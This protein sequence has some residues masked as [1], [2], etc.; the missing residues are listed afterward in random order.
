[1]P[2]V[3]DLSRAQSD[4][5]RALGR[6][7]AGEDRD[8]GQRV[9]EAGE[10]ISHLLAG[11]LKLTRVHSPD[12]HAFDQPV[13]ELGKALA[14]LVGQL[15]TVHLAAVED[16]VYVNDIRIRSDARSGMRDLG[17]DLRRHGMGGLSFHAPLDDRA[18][19]DLV[20]VLSAEPAP[21]HPRAALAER[22]RERGITS[23]ETAGIFRFRT[24]GERDRRRVPEEVVQRMYAVAAETLD[25]L[26]AGRALNPLPLRRAV[27]E[28]LDTDVA[29]PAFWAAPPATAPLHAAHAVE[30]TVL[31]LLLARAARF[32]AAFLQ[33]VGI[34]AMVHDV[35]YF[36]PGLDG[37]PDAL[38]RHPL[39]GARVLL[40]QRGFQEGKL[41]RL[42]AV[43]EHHRD[44]GAAASPASAAGLVLRIAEDYANGV[45]LYAARALRADLLGA[46]LRAGTRYSAPLVQVLVNALGRF[47]PGT[48]VELA[49]GRRA[50]VA[51]PARGPDLWAAPLLRILDAGGTP[52]AELVDAARGVEIRR[53]VPG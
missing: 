8:L 18:I 42:R 2:G 37:A 30:V 24:E 19:R 51:A 16:Q 6:A 22:L 35:G 48:V 44:A 47:P 41:R 34:A 20:A 25:N 46:M 17:G 49:D 11:L 53:A 40:R 36:A 21:S 50:R 32:P 38:A 43:L 45:R 33:D 52:T 1:M 27:V 13:T 7:R 39:E 15:G 3:D 28:A 9:R 5:A 10:Q 12:N 31:S 26:A 23:V 4:L 14:A 29:A